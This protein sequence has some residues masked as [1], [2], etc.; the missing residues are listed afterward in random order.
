MRIAML[1][2]VMC[3]VFWSVAS[4]PASAKA[5]SSKHTETGLASVYSSYFEG[6][7]TAS[8]ERYRQ[9]KNTAAHRSLPLG[10]TVRIT[11]L[12]N[13]HSTLVRIN[14]RGPHGNRKRIL[15]L[16][17]A[18]AHKLRLVGVMPVRMEIVEL[19]RR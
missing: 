1:V 19:A 6:T 7:M 9:D 11:N 5:I 2:S 14:D 15:D 18:A 4:H 13:G 10:S 16:S 3:V 8:G 12:K 17:A